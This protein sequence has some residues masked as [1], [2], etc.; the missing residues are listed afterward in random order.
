MR[1]KRAD[2]G[3]ARAALL[4]LAGVRALVALAAIPLAPVLYEH[5]F[6]A[7][8]LMRPTK[9]VLLAAGFLVRLGEV[10]LVPVLAAALPL[11]ILGVWQFYA[12]GRLY[13][14]D[15]RRGNI[16]RLARRLLPPERIKHMAKL[17]DR[18][19]VR[20]VFLGRLAAFPSTVVATAAGSGGMD[21]RSFLAAD[22]IGGALSIAEVLAAGF[23]LGY[24]YKRAGPWITVAGIA[25]LVVASVIVARALRRG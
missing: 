13:R 2:L 5:H 14:G 8:V 15:I 23:G 16:P 22:A 4:A 25:V 24:A 12:L 11:A 18:K 1:V 19:G 10:D 21:P 7:L 6:V 3:R 17:L 20:L 9:E